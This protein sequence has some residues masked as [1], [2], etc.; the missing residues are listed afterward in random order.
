MAKEK[1]NLKWKVNTPGLLK[2]VIEHNEGMGIFKVPFNIFT[3]LLMAVAKR[4]AE[5]DDP[6]LNSLMARL[7]LYEQTDPNNPAYDEKLTNETIYYEKS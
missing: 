3:R 7:A 5:L 4:S 6:K 1:I 2:E